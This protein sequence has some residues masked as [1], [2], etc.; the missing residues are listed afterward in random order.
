MSWAPQAQE[1]PPDT[2]KI[3]KLT[4]VAALRQNLD[5]ISASLD[6]LWAFAPGALAL[7]QKTTMGESK[8]ASYLYSDQPNCLPPEPLISSKFV[9]LHSSDPE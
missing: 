4:F 9:R 7:K 3:P 6:T 1:W 2:G 5:S 8:V